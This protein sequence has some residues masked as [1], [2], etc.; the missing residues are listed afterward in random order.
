MEYQHRYFRKRESIPFPPAPANTKSHYSPQ[1]AWWMAQCS[2]LSY[3][4]KWTVATEL[5]Q[6]GFNRITF[7]DARGTQAFLAERPSIDGSA[8]F[9]VLA[10]RGTEQDSIDILTD[11]NFVKRLFPD[12]NL[13]EEIAETDPEKKFAKKKPASSALYAHGGFLE[14]VNNVWG[15]KLRA[16]VETIYAEHGQKSVTWL[17]APGISDALCELSADTALYFTGHSLGGALATI[18]AYKALIYQS[19]VELTGLYTFGS[20]RTAQMPLAKKI[21]HELKGKLHRIVNHL[22]L[23][24][25]LPP[26]IPKL[27]DFHHIH[28]LIYFTGSRKPKMTMTEVEIFFLDVSILLLAIFEVLLCLLTFRRYIPGTIKQHMINEYIKDIEAQI[29]K[30]T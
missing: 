14:G 29:L 23:V 17:G 21:N 6:V 18:A 11:I 20:P 3:E 7:F 15:T 2:K 22:D 16:E 10:F 8:K 19:T 28:Q 13:L 25:R 9:A 5:K 30:N 26:Y 4:N 24:P 12:E 1:I 27:L